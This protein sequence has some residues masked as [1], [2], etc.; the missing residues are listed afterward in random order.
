[1]D[2]WINVTHHLNKLK[3]KKCRIIS[4]DAE[5]AYGKIQKPFIINDMKKLGYKEITQYIN[6]SLRKANINLKEEILNANLK[7]GT[8]KVCP[9][10][11][12]LFYKEPEV[13]FKAIKQLKEIKWV[14]TWKEEVKDSLFEDDMIIC[15]SHPENSTGELTQL[16]NIL[17]K[18]A[19]YTKLNSLSSFQ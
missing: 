8:R 7:S 10:S 12:Y 11:N 1:M 2:K 6:S 14:W 9:L 18:V 13:L 15:I 4:S 16:I 3:D 5:K 19:G 17:S